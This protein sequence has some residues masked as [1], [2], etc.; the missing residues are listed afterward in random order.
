MSKTRRHRGDETL[1]MALACGATVEGAAH[2][3]KLSVRT[4]YRRLADP[5]F[6]ARL[7]QARAELAR[8]AAGLLTAASL[9][10]VRTLVE[11]QGVAA[12]PAARLGAARAVIG[13]GLKLREET[14]LVERVAELERRLE[15]AA[16]GPVTDKG[17]EDRC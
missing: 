1:L 8:R 3:A 2:K 15:E 17:G 14:D 16:A 7:R 5:A 10:S 12:P 13:L 4:A 11:L 6:Q 9:E